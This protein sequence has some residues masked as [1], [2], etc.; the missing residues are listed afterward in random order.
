MG[1]MCNF[2]L[3]LFGMGNITTRAFTYITFLIEIIVLFLSLF[4][5]LSLFLLFLLLPFLLFDGLSRYI[6]INSLRT[7]YLVPAF[8]IYACVYTRHPLEKRKRISPVLH[9][10]LLRCSATQPNLA[11]LP[12]MVPAFSG[13][14][15]GGDAHFDWKGADILLVDS[16]PVQPAVECGQFLARLADL[17][18]LAL[19]LPLAPGAL[20]ALEQVPCP[21]DGP[22]PQHAHRAETQGARRV[23]GG[24]QQKVPYHS[25]PPVST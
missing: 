23:R 4:L 5:S 20:D 6:H 1:M 13:R 15:I 16:N 19:Q 24:V 3:G 7:I 10:I 8:N 11:A 25:C 14:G 21:V 18:V 9:L 2:Y 17:V 22:V 12:T